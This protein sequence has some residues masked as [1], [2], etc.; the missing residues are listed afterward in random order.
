MGWE[1]YYVCVCGTVVASTS[2]SVYVRVHGSQKVLVSPQKSAI[3][4]NWYN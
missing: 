4:K 3:S 1:C 2:I